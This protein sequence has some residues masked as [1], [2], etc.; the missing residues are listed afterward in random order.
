MICIKIKNHQNY[1][2]VE[3]V[4]VEPTSKDNGT[5]ASTS[6][7]DILAIRCS[8]GLST[9]FRAASL[10]VLF[11]LPQTARSGVVHLK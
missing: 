11:L 9:G 2:L 3:T 10:V 4:G 5:Y 1:V 7:V 8:F 6:V